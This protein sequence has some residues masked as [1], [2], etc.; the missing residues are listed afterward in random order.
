[1]QHQWAGIAVYML[2][3]MCYNRQYR[4]N[5]PEFRL[6]PIGSMDAIIVAHQRNLLKKK[7]IIKEKKQY[8]IIYR[9]Y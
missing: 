1:M 6:V 5:L 2:H 8:S 4:E 7:P 9:G 3:D